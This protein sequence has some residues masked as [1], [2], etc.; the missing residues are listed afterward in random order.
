MKELFASLL[1]DLKKYKTYIIVGFILCLIIGFLI[2]IFKEREI[3]EYQKKEQ[4]SRSNPI[5]IY[6]DEYKIFN[7]DIQNE[8]LIDTD[9]YEEEPDENENKENN[10]NQ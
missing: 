5:G 1:N 10:N 3:D 8:D 6:R 2:G 4:E 9:K 7:L